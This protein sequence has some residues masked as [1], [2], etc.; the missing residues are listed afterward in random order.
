VRRAARRLLAA[1]LSLAAGA[2]LAREERGAE[3]GRF[4]FYV[5][6]LTWSPTYCAEEGA[7]RDDGQCD[8]G[9]R[10][11]FVVHGLWPQ[12]DRGFPTECGAFPRQPTRAALEE[13]ATIYPSL[14]LARHQWR[15]HGTCSGKGPPEYFRDVPER[16]AKLTAGDR[17]APL[18]LERAFVAAN[19]GL[20]ADMMGVVCRG[21]RLR[22]VRICFDRELK[23]FQTCPQVD[24]SGCRGGEV[25]L[26]PPR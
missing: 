22:E 15:R 20:R 7:R 3:P 25:T 18:E 1:I 26:D 19:P 4:D 11:G 17:L 9:R 24:R 14:S 10:L 5:L 16:F 23:G 8:V 12:H 13:A 6:A 2:A 21:G